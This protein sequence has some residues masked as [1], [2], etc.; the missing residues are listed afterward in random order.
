MPMSS[1]EIANLNAAFSQQNMMRM[2][3]SGMVAP[4]Y[5]LGGM[6]SRAGHEGMAA[7]GMSMAAGIGAPMAGLG[8]G[9]MGL[10]PISMGVRSGAAAMG[11]GAGLA[12]GAMAGLAVGGGMMAGMGAISYMG[13]QVMAGMQQSQ[14]FGSAMRSSYSFFNPASSSGRGFTSGDNREIGNHMRSISGGGGMQHMGGT[15]DQFGTGPGFNE[16]GRLASSMGRMGLADGVRNVKEFKEK[17][18][19]MIKTVTTIAHD[20]GTTLEEAQKAMASMKGSGIFNKQGAISS[21]IRSASIS[22][23][24]ATTEVTGMMN[25]GSQIS[26][27]FG[28]TGRQGALGG[29]EA[30]SQVGT[31][32]QTGALSEEDIYQATGQT[33]A[34]GRRAMA[35]Q[36]MLQTGS[37]LKSGKGRYLLASLAGKNGKLDGDSV[38]DFMSGGM[39]VEDTRQAARRNLGKVGRANFIRNEGRLRGAVM[40]EFGGLAPAMAMMGWAQGKGIDINSM[41]DREMLFMQRQMGMGRDEADALVKMARKM[42]DL[43]QARRNAKDDAAGVQEHHMRKEHSGLEGVKHKLEHARD[44]VNNEMQKVGQ[45]ILNAATDKVAEWGNRL[46]GV[47]EE[48]S[49]GGI[50]ETARAAGLGGARG[51]EM[52]QSLIGGGGMIAS[53]GGKGLSGGGSPHENTSQRAFL[54]KQADLQFAARLGSAGGMSDEMKGLVSSNSSALKEAYASELSGLSGEDRLAGFKRKFGK[55]TEIG[56]KYR[57]MGEHDQAA[58]MQQMEGEIG[59]R[60][61][62]LSETFTKFGPAG[63]VGGGEHFTEAQRQ[64]AQGSALLGSKRG[65]GARALDIATGAVG[66]DALAGLAGGISGLFTGKGFAAGFNGAAASGRRA[67]GDYAEEVTGNAKQ[68]RAAGAYFD[69][70]EGRSMAS[71]VLSGAK[72]ADDRLNV[73]IANIKGGASGRGGKMTEEELGQMGVLQQVKLTADLMKVANSKGGLERMSDSDWDKLIQQRKLT[74]KEP[75][76]V[77]KASILKEARMVEGAALEQRKIVSEKLAKDAGLSGRGDAQALHAGGVAKLIA[78]KSGNVLE[79][80]GDKAK[81]M[82]K[83]GGASGQALE[84]AIESMNLGMQAGSASTE[85][86]QRSL[87]ERKF[88][89]DLKLQD[90]MG[91]MDVKGLRAFGGAMAGT[92]IGGQASELLM[93]GQSLTAGTRRKGAAGAIAA[94]LGLNLG[95]DEMAALK[96]K[97]AEAGAAAIAARL[98]VGDD[99]NFTSGLQEAIAAASKKGGGIQG[100]QLLQRALGQADEGTK[101]KLEEMAKGQASPDEKILDKLAEGNKFLETLV[102]SNKTMNSSLNI[103]AGNTSK[104]DAEAPPA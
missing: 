40:E 78:G 5:N 15:M 63:L 50:R 44:A 32:V 90:K 99:K 16:L 87:L 8:M 9:L 12:G 33:G 48:R 85:E 13:N 24:L 20:M 39:G 80:S 3:Y 47:Y 23:N 104:S 75:G 68:N 72:G 53:L 73:A 97:S 14:Q 66:G 19:E 57:G 54:N 49:I 7:R 77:T 27:M 18:S 22:G 93:R 25:V 26:R 101:K 35:Q 59:I 94:Q 2:Q 6:N 37:F 83:A 86:G 76:E 10:D 21:A 38:A 42:P 36:Q 55:D 89:T 84:L 67:A 79:I 70:A 34:E 91:L 51:R 46:A 31:A 45:D 4:E 92:S 62:R 82:V 1:A 98:G 65:L 56:R 96:G 81:E 100:A 64:E 43:L 102:N 61:G 28:G 58:F 41:G 103:I 69:S 29:I 95:P 74:S 52:M 11:G 88:D 30:I 17:F 60:N 71:D